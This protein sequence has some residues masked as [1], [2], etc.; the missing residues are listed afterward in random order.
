L[1]GEPYAE[2][3]L[4][5]STLT[6]DATLELSFDDEVIEALSVD[7]ILK[8]QF[9]S[10]LRDSTI[11]NKT[12]LFTT[13]ES[14]KDLLAEHTPALQLASSQEANY[15]LKFSK[16]ALFD[17]EALEKMLALAMALP[18]SIII[19]NDY[20][21]SSQPYPVTE[22]GSTV[23]EALYRA[24]FVLYSNS[25]K[26]VDQR[27]IRMRR[28]A[29]SFKLTP[30]EKIVKERESVTAIIRLHKGADFDELKRA[31]Y[32]LASS[33]ETHV[34]PLI[35]LQDLDTTQK[36]ELEKILAAIP[37]AH[38]IEPT[39]IDY[40]TMGLEG[41]LRTLM[42]ND[43][44]KHVKSRY[45]VFLDHDDLIFSDA[46]SWLLDRLKTTGKAVSFGRVYATTFDS[47][48]GVL[49]KRE[50]DFEYG[51]SYE[52]FL[53]DNH[54]PIHSFMLDLEQINLAQVVYHEDQKYMEDYY[55]TL[56]IF[57]KQSG[58]WESLRLNRY[59][60]DY[61]HSSDREHTLAISDAKKKEELLN[62]PIYQR[63]EQRIVDLRKSL[64]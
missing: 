44:L 15:T 33:F 21:N 45:A 13:Q 3:F 56:Q 14:L 58:D 55:L 10:A 40:G 26:R 39:V 30:S 51:Y 63:D 32:S 5:A 22:N 23:A 1:A 16:P 34:T 41:D 53:S 57:S 12:T 24:P 18:E 9:L 29:H 31:L 42:M 20:T 43:A 54:A 19:P 64:I 37:F 62:D 35:T 60:G 2:Q 25:S 27:N 46:Y 36:K 38:N 4:A 8:E 59:I 48:L 28:D 7:T 47:K 52:D 50:K 49:T 6:Q 61:I 11:L 17:G